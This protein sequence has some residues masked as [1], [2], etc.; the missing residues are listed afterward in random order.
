MSFKEKFWSIVLLFSTILTE[1]HTF[2]IELYPNEAKKEYN[3]F[4]QP[5]GTFSLQL[6]WWLK[7]LTET[8]YLL[9]LSFAFTRFREGFSRRFYLILYTYIA[10]HV[11]DF[12][13]FLYNFKHYHRLYWIALSILTISQLFII[14]TKRKGLHPV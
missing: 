4:L 8:L 12:I 5:H 9:L 1:F 2:L 14:F 3:L 11:F 7:S 6:D 13:S 10:Y